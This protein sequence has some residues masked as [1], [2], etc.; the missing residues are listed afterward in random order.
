MDSSQLFMRFM[1]TNPRFLLLRCHGG[2]R[3]RACLDVVDWTLE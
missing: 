2:M 3:V 1:A